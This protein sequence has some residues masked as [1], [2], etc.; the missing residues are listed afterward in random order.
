MQVAVIGG[1]FTGLACATVLAQ[2]GIDVVLYEKN[3]KL[4]GLA[5]GFQEPAWNSSLETYYHHWFRSDSHVFKFAKIWNAQDGIFF[6][7]PSTVIQT[8]EYG[9]VPLDSAKTLLQ[10]PEL[11]VT[12]KIR[13]GATLAFLKLSRH[14][15]ALERL[16]AEEWCLKYMGEDAFQKIWK[17]LLV[18][19]F[20]EK[21]AQE[22]NMAWL[23][24][25][26]K[27]RS[28]EL[29]S[30]QGG[31]DQFIQRA[32]ESLQGFGV[33][34]FKNVQ[35]IHVDRTRDYWT[36]AAL[37]H[38][39]QE[40]HALVV[41]TSPRAFSVLVGQHAPEHVRMT[42]G[43]P[44]LGVQV[45]ILVLK[46]KLG[47]HYWY[48][49]KRSIAQPFLA[50]IEH[51]NFVDASHYN[52]ETILYFAKYVKSGTDEWKQTDEHLVDLA[53][54]ACRAINPDFSDDWLIRSRVFRE[55]YAQPIAGVNGSR[56]VPSIHVH[57]V[58][59]LFHAS[60]AHVYPWDRGTNYA[61]ELGERTAHEVLKSLPA[62]SPK[63]G[64]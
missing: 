1:G 45:I 33:R 42:L 4:G 32:E 61:L 22:I 35:K 6:R 41:A 36:V 50:A 26:L 34:I 29:G 40:H 11:G 46:R 60:M 7:R 28:A 10:Y 64:A 56:F 53:L 52:N 31:F 44:A 12:S 27:C 21:H 55:E 16:T 8:D 39:I 2:R 14:W 49:L 18:G 48:S 5:A 17:P 9:F 15:R 25:R 57:G 47:D 62:R 63:R 3:E 37:N 19:K 58:S 51:T 54:I 13:L 38:G 30:Y 24:A 59:R 43:Q 20:G 23:W